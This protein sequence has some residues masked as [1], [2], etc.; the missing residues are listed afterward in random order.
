VFTR[1]YAA[2]LSAMQTTYKV[3]FWHKL[4]DQHY[5]L[6]PSPHH[7]ESLKSYQGYDWLNMW[8]SKKCMQKLH[9][10]D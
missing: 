1:G 9:M 10:E 7:H 5:S 2:G 3:V 4:E 8:V 6:A